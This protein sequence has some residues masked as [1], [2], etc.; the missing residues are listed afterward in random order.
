VSL[1]SLLTIDG[2]VTAVSVGTTRDER[3]NLSRTKGTPRPVKCYVEQTDAREVII[4][5]E[6]Y[7]VDAFGILPTGDPITA[8]DELTARGQ[9]FEVI[10]PPD[11]AYNPRL[12]VDHHVEV[13]LR[14]VTG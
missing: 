8:A 10:G 13:N 12:A 5:R 3:G 11:A 9:T 7:T 1:D 4:D 6:T 14:S 2:T